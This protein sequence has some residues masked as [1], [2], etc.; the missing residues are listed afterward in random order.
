MLGLSF[1]EGLFSN[2]LKVSQSSS[3]LFEGP[4]LRVL[5]FRV[6]GFCGCRAQGYLG[7]PGLRVRALGVWGLELRV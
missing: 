5:S 3:K 1:K 2:G 4:G 7:V 6:L